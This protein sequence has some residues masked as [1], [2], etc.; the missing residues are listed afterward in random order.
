MDSTEK[1]DK[2]MFENTKDIYGK[3]MESMMESTMK[4]NE[5][6]M[7]EIKLLISELKEIK[8]EIGELRGE[9]QKLEN[10]V[11]DLV[12][13]NKE[14]EEHVEKLESQNKKLELKFELKAKEQQLRI[15][16]L[17]E[18]E[19]EENIR[20]KIINMFV[21][22]TEKPIE[23][24]EKG[25]DQVFRIKLRAGRRT[26]YPQDVI[27]N[28]LSKTLKEEILRQSYAKPIEY[29]NEKV[30]IMKELPRQ[31]VEDRKSY[32]KLTDN[33]KGKNKRF[34]WELP[35]GLS[36]TFKGERKYIPSEAQMNDL[37]E[38]ISKEQADF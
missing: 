34:R 14:L 22:L 29:R 21:E 8:L 13:R 11:T 37:L 26:N 35:R 1:L 5:K 9:T 16:G 7:G 12:N 31:I 25:M 4:S 32:K 6:M 17:E 19:E 27:V 28:V 38:L 36:L 15:R 24:I 30:L 10:K 3:M 2:K 18:E 20:E 23:E 33:L